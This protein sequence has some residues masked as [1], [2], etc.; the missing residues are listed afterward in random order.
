MLGTAGDLAGE[1]EGVG[2]GFMCL[3][4]PETPVLTQP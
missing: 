2:R 4:S 1:K 3:E